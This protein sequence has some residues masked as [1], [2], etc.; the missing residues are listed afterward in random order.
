MEVRKAVIT[1][2][3]LGTRFLPATKALS[4]E[5]LPLV[6]RPLIQYALE[7]CASS[8]IE[9]VII[10]IR[11]EQGTI[12]EHCS[13]APEL[14]RMLEDKG[15][16]SELDA[17]RNVSSLADICYVHQAEQL[18]L[19]HAILMAKDAVGDEPF[20]VILPDDIIDGQV[21]ALGQMKRIYDQY[22]GSVVA[23][24]HIAEDKVSSYG[25]VDPQKIDDKVSRVLGLV[26]KPAP[27]KA[28][29][30]LCIVGR[31][32][33]TPQIFDMI[34][35]TPRGAI[36]EIQITDAMQLL[37]QEQNMYAYAFDGKRH[38]TGTPLGMLK[39]SV[40]LGLKNAAFG[41]EFR[42][43]LAQLEL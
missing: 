15:K 32:I 24:E 18:G 10:I 35:K 19:G 6:D 40:E 33:F 31:Y 43:Y 39:A 28:P 21:P 30:D 25:V 20:A 17:V 2:A 11:P 8:G 16:T 22:G 9:Q 42:E 5:M 38:D 4:K 12:G 29:S 26:E 13:P 37:L 1:A 23:V 34:E 7:E 14:E 36:G 41:D 27:D 3:G